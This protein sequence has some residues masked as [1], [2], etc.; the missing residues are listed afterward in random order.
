MLGRRVPTRVGAPFR[1]RDCRGAP[2]LLA[3]GVGGIVV[4]DGLRDGHC[5]LNGL[6]IPIA[7]GHVLAGLQLAREAPVVRDAA[8]VEGGPHVRTRNLIHHAG[9]GLPDR[10]GHHQ[11]HHHDDRLPHTR[12]QGVGLGRDL[13]TRGHEGRTGD[14]ERSEQ[15]L[16]DAHEKHPITLIHSCQVDRNSTTR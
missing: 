5:H 12:G 14:Q 1:S 10:Q 13:V 11:G 6:P 3:T 4:E 7:E 16:V 15:H 2:A 8:A 9:D